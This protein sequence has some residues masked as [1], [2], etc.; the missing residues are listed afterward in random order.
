[1][2]CPS[3]IRIEC[4]RV[5]GNVYLDFMDNGDGIP[6]LNAEKIFDAFFTTTSANG[7]SDDDGTLAGMGMGLKVVKDIVETAHG[8][9]T[10]RPAPNDF[11][12][13]FRVVIPEATDEEIP[14]NAY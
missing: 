6:T 12:T 14:A 13:C 4:G 7:A 10:L 2:I 1:V 5:S 8:E 9:I 3:G 11:A